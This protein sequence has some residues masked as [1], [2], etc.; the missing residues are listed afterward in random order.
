MSSGSIPSSHRERARGILLAE[1]REGDVSPPAAAAARIFDQLH[2]CLDPLLGAGGVRLLLQRSAKLAAVA[3]PCFAAPGALESS[4]K[5]RQCLE[6]EE[7]AAVEEAAVAFYASFFALITSFLG[8]RL[9]TEVLRRAWPKLGH[10]EPL[11]K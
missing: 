10:S 3:S 1:R 5:F 4:T 11:E 7:P 9:I 6:A 2:L 8:E